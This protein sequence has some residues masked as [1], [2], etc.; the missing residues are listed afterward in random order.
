MPAS[1]EVIAW[2]TP[3]NLYD[4]QTWEVDSS[5]AAAQ[6]LGSCQKSL[7]SKSDNQAQLRLTASRDAGRLMWQTRVLSADNQPLCEVNVDARTGEIR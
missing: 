3:P 4:D 5:L 1:P 7:E 6:F 2:N